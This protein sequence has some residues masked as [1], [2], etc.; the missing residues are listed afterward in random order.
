[1][2]K[3]YKH[4]TRGNNQ[5]TKEEREKERNRE[6]LQKQLENCLK[7]WNKYTSTNNYFK[8]KWAKLANQ[9]IK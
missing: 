5:I 2:R 3:K 1:M 8:C 4:N 7:K 6:E 9:K